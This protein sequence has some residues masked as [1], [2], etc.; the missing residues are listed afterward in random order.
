MN[1]Q[2]DPGTK[3]EEAAEQQPASEA[4]TQDAEEG[5]TEG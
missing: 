3:Q 2:F 5:T 1:T 4:P